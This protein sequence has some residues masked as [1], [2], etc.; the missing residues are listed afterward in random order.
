ME[1]GI[2]CGVLSLGYI[3]TD[4]TLVL[5]ESIELR[6]ILG[7]LIVQLRHFVF[8]YFIALHV[9][10]N[11]LACQLVSVVIRECDVNIFLL[12]GGHADNLLLKTGDE[13][14]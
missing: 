1:I 2:G 8:F 7:K 13:R 4:A 5:L 12:A 10:Y 6:N 11:S 9:E 3:L 14:T